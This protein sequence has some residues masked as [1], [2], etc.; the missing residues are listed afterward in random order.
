LITTSAEFLAT[1]QESEEN[2]GWVEFGEPEPA[3]EFTGLAD[4]EPS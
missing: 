4:G 2:S 1:L 3:L